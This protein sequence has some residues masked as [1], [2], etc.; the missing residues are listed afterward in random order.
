MSQLTSIPIIGNE[1]GAVNAVYYNGERTLLAARRVQSE[2]V[3]L[4]LLT[5]CIL[6]SSWIL[7]YR[8]SDL[9]GR[10]YTKFA[11][12]ASVFL[13]TLAYS[14][15]SIVGIVVALTLSVLIPHR[16]TRGTRLGRVIV[17]GVATS[18]LVGLPV[19]IGYQYGLFKNV[20]D[21]FSGRVLAGIAP[22]VIAT[23]PSV[24][25][26]FVEMRAAWSYVLQHP[27]FGTG[28]GAFY[29]PRIADEPFVGDQGRL[30]LH[31]YFALL[32][33][34]FGIVCGLLL[35]VAFL[36]CAVRMVRAGNQEP[37]GFSEMWPAMAC[38]FI[39]LLTVSAV[40]PVMYSR[41]FIAFGGC[42]LACGLSLRAS[43][44]VADTRRRW[45]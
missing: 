14:R 30:Y 43:E 29:R 10:N 36:I 33:V 42:L 32:G 41:S 31:N 11:I 20:I 39:A 38:G 8:I 23:D 44:A 40:A 16:S 37:S 34:K 9:I 25:W 6:C 26:R 2:P 13:T 19:W 4:A 35:L 21:T 12:V 1:A 15:N 28:F 27:L 3:P 24:G 17:L 7:R 5:F 45:K 22:E 18:V